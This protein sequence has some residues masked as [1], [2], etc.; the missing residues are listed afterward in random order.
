MDKSLLLYSSPRNSGSSKKILS[1]SIKRCLEAVF[2][3]WRVFPD[4][5]ICKEEWMNCQTHNESLG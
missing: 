2:F 1:A 4:E 5:E 3:I